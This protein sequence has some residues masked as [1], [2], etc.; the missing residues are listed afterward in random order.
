VLD[1]QEL[2]KQLWE[3]AD[4]MRKDYISFIEECGE[5]E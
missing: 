5:L 2:I 3:K 1:L 4:E